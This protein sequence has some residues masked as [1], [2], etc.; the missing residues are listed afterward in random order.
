MRTPVVRAK[1]QRQHRDDEQIE[2]NPKEE[3][4]KSYDTGRRCRLSGLKPPQYCGTA[5]N[6]RRANQ[7]PDRFSRD[8]PPETRALPYS[9]LPRFPV[10]HS[11]HMPISFIS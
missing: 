3:H 11:S 7:T 8:L 2:E 5:A 1:I 9:A 10:A 4:R 6:S